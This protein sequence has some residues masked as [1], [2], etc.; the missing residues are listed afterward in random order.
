[1]GRRRRDWESVRAGNADRRPRARGGRRRL[2]SFPCDALR[3]HMVHMD[4]YVKGEF[5]PTLMQ[6]TS[7][8]MDTTST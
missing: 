5:Y 2:A 4:A 8:F 6:S 3:T 7:G 1:M